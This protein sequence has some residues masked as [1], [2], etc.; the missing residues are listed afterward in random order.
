MLAAVL[1]GALL[2]GR[3]G[4]ETFGAAGTVVV[5]GVAGLADAHA[6]ALAAVQLAAQGQVSA[7]TAAWAVA[8]ALAT[9]TVLKMLLAFA[10]GGVGVGLRFAALLVLPV[11]R[12]R[13]PPGRR[14]GLSRRRTLPG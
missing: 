4:Q 12:L 6:G 9:N 10:A 14:P 3:W 5:S 2:L 1:T 11:V 8:A 13:R 7:A